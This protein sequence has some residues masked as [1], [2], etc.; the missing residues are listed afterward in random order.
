MAHPKPLHPLDDARSKSEWA[1]GRLD[2]LDSEIRAICDYADSHGVVVEY[3]PNQG[4]YGA[5]TWLPGKQP[6]VRLSLLLGEVIHSARASLDFVTWQLA[7]KF[8]S[9]EPTEDEAPSIQFP[10]AYSANSFA[11]KKVL[12]LIAGSAGQEISLHQPYA[13]NPRHDLAILRW[14]SNRDKHRLVLP[15][16]TTVEFGVRTYHY[17]PGLPVGLD[18]TAIR[19]RGPDFTDI[20]SSFFTGDRSKP[21]LEWIEFPEPLD[22]KIDVEAATPMEIRF[23]GPTGY[24]TVG[25]IKALLDYVDI[26]LVGFDRFF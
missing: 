9:R 8:L 12:S 11:K 7:I 4:R 17:D 19:H 24:I 22:V 5:H 3:D 1:K 18:V 13:P 21:V 10:I 26:I 14:L 25:E 2:D 23:S 15:L 20:E 6:L 16:F